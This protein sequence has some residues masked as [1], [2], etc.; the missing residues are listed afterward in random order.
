MFLCDVATVGPMVHAL[1][2]A[3]HVGLAGVV[4]LGGSLFLGAGLLSF[5]RARRAPRD[6]P[7]DAGVTSQTQE[8]RMMRT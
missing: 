3:L 5:R 2:L 4:S 7:A 6:T 8:P 1:H